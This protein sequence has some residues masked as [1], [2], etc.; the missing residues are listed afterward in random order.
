GKKFDKTC[1]QQ[2]HRVYGQPNGNG[3]PL[4]ETLNQRGTDERLL[5]QIARR[6]NMHFWIAYT[7]Q[8]NGLDPS[9]DSLKVEEIANLR[10]SPLR[11]E[12]AK[13]LLDRQGIRLHPGVD[14]VL[15]VNVEKEQCQNVTTFRLWEDAERP[16]RFRGIAVD[17]RAGKS[18]PTTA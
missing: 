3:E 13:N 2:T 11:P 5:C 4:V 12:D 18:N 1:I 10:S 16:S 17:D 9:G 14:V 7:C 15:R 6:N 8:R